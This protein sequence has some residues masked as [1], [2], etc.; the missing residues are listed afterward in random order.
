[1]NVQHINPFIRSTREVFDTMIHVPIQLGR[2]A[3]KDP[4]ARTHKLF[5]ISATVGLNGATQG[6][7]I[8]SFSETVALALASALAGENFK[9]LGTD[10]IDALGEIANMIVGS[11]KKDLPGGQVSITCP[12]V[13]PTADITYPP[14]KPVITIPFDTPTGRFAIEV[15]VDRQGASAPVDSPASGDAGTLP[16]CDSELPSL[17]S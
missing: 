12:S 4:N 10:A 3:L 2:P 7:V 14:A 13:K 8:L 6:T 16:A 11:A 15:V 1:M 5:K 9:F 17:S